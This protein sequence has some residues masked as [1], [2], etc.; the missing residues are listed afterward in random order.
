MRGAHQRA[1][2]AVLAYVEDLGAEEVLA[3]G[4][5]EAGHDAGAA[6][7]VLVVLCRFLGLWFA[8]VSSDAYVARLCPLIPKLCCPGQHWARRADCHL[9]GLAW[10]LP[11]L[12]PLA[13]RPAVAD[14]LAGAGCLEHVA[15]L[16]DQV[17]TAL[18]RLAVCS[19]QQ[20]TR[21][22]SLHA[23]V[24]VWLH[25]LVAVCVELRLLAVGRPT[26]CCSS[27]C[28]LPA[29]RRAACTLQ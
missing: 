27:C 19:S 17:R 16:L 28:S 8:Q 18:A 24:A 29:V 5:K 21:S 12:A 6:A 15:R 7:D 14:A 10:L 25:A 1:A 26:G 2:A 9:Q 11:A 23:L 20:G 4:E 22:G 3:S 13:A